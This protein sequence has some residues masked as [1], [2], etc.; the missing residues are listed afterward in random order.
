MH[1]NILIIEDNLADIALIEAYLKAAAFR[2][3]LYASESLAEGLGILEDTKI[4]LVLLDLR[5]P[6]MEGFQTLRVF[7]E[8]AP[9]MPV[10]VLT[11]FRNEVMG[12][13]SVRAGAQDYLVKGDFDAKSLVRA[14]RYALQRFEMQAKLQ[15]QA[16]ELSQSQRRNK[17]AHQI[18]RFGKWEMDIVNNTMVWDDEIFSFFGFPPQCFTPTLSDYLRYVHVADRHKVEH[19]FEQALKHGRPH[20]IKHR[21]VIDNT[22]VKRL[23]AKA[24][25]NYDQPSNRILLMG[26]VQDISEDPAR[27][28]SSLGNAKASPAPAAPSSKASF[29]DFELDLQPSLGTLSSLLALLEKTELTRQQRSLA[30]G[31]KSTLNELSLALNNWH[32]LQACR[33]G[34]LTTSPAP[35][36]L[37]GLI[38]EVSEA[39]QSRC[40]ETGL[41]FELEISPALPPT[42]RIDREKVAQVLYNLLEVSVR[43][44]P[45]GS[46]IKPSLQAEPL[47]PN[48][49]Q[50]TFRT[51]FSNPALPAEEARALLEQSLTYFDADEQHPCCLLTVIAARLAQAMGGTIDISED[52]TGAIQV[53][54]CQ[55]LTAADTPPAAVPERPQS[56]VHILLVEDHDLQRLTLERTLKAWSSMVSVDVAENGKEALK[57]N[58]RHAYHLILMDL[59]MPGWDGL[60]AAARIRSETA[61]PIIALSNRESAEERG[62]S[63][64][65]GIYHYLVKP[66]PPQELFATIMQ[67]LYG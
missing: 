36:N 44:S 60:E 67:A 15:E 40:K 4:D 8:K 52:A 32:Y 61:V 16:T 57:K 25:I 3:K 41:Q 42:M 62:R 18:A 12:I 22:I 58:R 14:I 64:A 65:I 50:L 56:P 66:V 11:G 13:Q 43:N 7:R 37:S 48:G 39:I 51:R 59:Q 27:L 26:T 53:T 28:S 34:A 6:D 2:H 63:A 29:T 1:T 19:F 30:D 10:I 5:L 55:P 49:R 17:L 54:Y 45:A 21:I 23:E 46:A 20:S 47:P 24:Q 38:Q 9:A 31:L 33:K 35:T